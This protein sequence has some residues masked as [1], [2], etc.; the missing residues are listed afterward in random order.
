MQQPT[1]ALVLRSVKYGES[2]LIT[3]LFTEAYGV[4]S[5]LV[6]G[7]RKSKKANAGLLQ[8]TLLLAIEID[9][10]PQRNL[11]FLRSFHFAYPYQSL[12]EDIVKNTIAIFATEVLLRLLPEQAT[13]HELFDFCFDFFTQLDKAPTSDIANYPIYFLIQTGVLLGFKIKGNYSAQTPFI[14]IEDGS[15]TAKEPLLSTLTAD[16]TQRLHEL[17]HVT[18]LSQLPSITIATACRY[19]LINWYLD[20]LRMHSQHLG[21]LKSLPILRTIL[22]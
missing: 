16:D 1:K 11:Q 22:H 6:K 2:S 17:L 21:T 20:F 12:Q 7:I 3:T 13:M 5:Y 10:K 18:T 15:F 4:Q 8:P 9:H 19:H 14:A